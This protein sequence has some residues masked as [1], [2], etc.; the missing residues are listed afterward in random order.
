MP[1][2]K[3]NKLPNR[4]FVSNVGKPL[5]D[6]ICSQHFNFRTSTKHDRWSD[7]V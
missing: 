6:F 5:H 3:D 1:E 2:L 7:A 4:E